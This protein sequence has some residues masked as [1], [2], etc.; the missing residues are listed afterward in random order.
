MHNYSIRIL[1][2]KYPIKLLINKKGLQIIANETIRITKR[3]RKSKGQSRMEN[4][5]TEVTLGTRN[6]TM[7]NKAKTQHRKLK[8]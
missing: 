3:E 5:E 4:P 6:R 2:I 7:T 8:R 1:A